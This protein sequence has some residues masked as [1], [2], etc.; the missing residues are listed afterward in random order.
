LN[1]YR[2]YSWREAGSNR[3]AQ[4]PKLSKGGQPKEPSTWTMDIKGNT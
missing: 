1:N 4:H 2:P 3:T